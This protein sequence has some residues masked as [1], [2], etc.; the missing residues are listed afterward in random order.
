MQ[1]CIV[2]EFVKCSLFGKIS[3]LKYGMTSHSDVTVMENI[4]VSVSCPNGNLNSV[5]TTHT[6]E[7][8]SCV[9]NH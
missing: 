1:C 2:N 7:P 5:L 6:T 3:K 4:S 8:A 9:C